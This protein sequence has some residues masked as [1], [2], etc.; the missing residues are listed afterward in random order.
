VTVVGADGTIL[1]GDWS[2]G[3]WDSPVVTVTE[4]V[5]RATL[6][7]LR[8]THGR[9]YRGGGVLNAGSLTLSK[10]TLTDNGAGGVGG[11]IANTGTL[12]LIESTVTKNGAVDGEGGGL[13]NWGTLRLADSVVA[14]NYAEDGGGGIA[15]QGRLTMTDSTIANNHASEVEGN[16][17]TGGGIDNFK[18][19]LTLT[20]CAVAG[21]LA[22]SA[23]GGI[24]NWRG[25]MTLT[26]C[27]ITNNRTTTIGGWGGLGGGIANDDGTVTLKDTRIAGNRAT[28]SGGGLSNTGASSRIALR[29]AS[30]VTNNDAD[31]THPESG[32]GI[33]NHL[34]HVEFVDTSRVTGNRPNDCTGVTCPG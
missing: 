32:G 10:C 26:E 17:G 1:K 4:Q 21:N 25:T 13:F 6:R 24:A 19:V 14:D 29:G 27:T 5:K 2:G 30:L 12:T 11:A 34:G 9:A 28:T 7:R 16:S 22:D 18:G 33:S 15:N 23:G 20:R 31:P 8:I 3:V